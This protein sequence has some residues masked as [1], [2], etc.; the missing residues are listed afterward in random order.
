M[1]VETL[2]DKVDTLAKD[3]KTTGP[4]NLG[5]FVND[6]QKGG[7][8]STTSKEQWKQLNDGLVQ[9]GVLNDVSIVGLE[10]NLLKVHDNKDTKTDSYRIEDKEQFL[11]DTQSQGRHWIEGPDGSR[12]VVAGGDEGETA[13][14]HEMI[15]KN[16]NRTVYNYDS[17]GLSQVQTYDKDGKLTQS[18]TKDG[19]SQGGGKESWSIKDAKGVSVI[20]N[21]DYFNEATGEITICSDHSSG[22]NNYQPEYT[23]ISDHGIRSG[24]NFNVQEGKLVNVVGT[25]ANEGQAYDANPYGIF[26][27]SAAHL[28]GLA[29]LSNGTFSV[30]YG[31]YQDV[32]D[33]TG[34]HVSVPSVGMTT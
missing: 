12:K 34:K 21:V 27:K 32:I 4:D 11:A 15:D 29:L 18:A 22:P 8:S 20:G 14:V 31:A 13:A 28:K 5:Q 10:G 2:K 33:V 24:W 23:H 3:S 26:S 19:S 9:A 16:G 17:K 6:L 25:G 30:D 7:Y 1:P